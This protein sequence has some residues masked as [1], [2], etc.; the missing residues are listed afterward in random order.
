MQTVENTFAEISVHYHKLLQIH[1]HL[2]YNRIKRTD[3]I[4]L[5]P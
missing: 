1:Q 3:V 4:Y 2:F 5:S